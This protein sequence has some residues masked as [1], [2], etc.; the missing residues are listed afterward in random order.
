MAAAVGAAVVVLGAHAS[1]PPLLLGGVVLAAV[2]GR[3]AIQVTGV[4]VVVAV[5]AL[6]R[7]GR[8]EPSAAALVTSAVVQAALRLPTDGP[9]ATSAALAALAIVPLA[10]V[11]A[12]RLPAVVRRPAKAIGL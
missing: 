7:R 5:V 3:P 11:G 8:V 2:G 10:V 1:W 4:L 12:A 9:V 6:Q